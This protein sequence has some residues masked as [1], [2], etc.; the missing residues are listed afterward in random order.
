V[1]LKGQI[2][3]KFVS[4][5]GRS[6][7]TIEMD[8]WAKNIKNGASTIAQL[9]EFLRATVEYI[10]RQEAARLEA[11]RLEALRI[12]AA[13]RLEAERAAKLAAE[14][15]EKLKLAE[16]SFSWMLK[17]KWFWGIVVVGVGSYYLIKRRK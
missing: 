7:T 16:A 3:A 15:A 8:T 11:A 1:T 9:E 10:A 2:D 12:A 6:P 17:N 14:R 13:A 5:T 4:F